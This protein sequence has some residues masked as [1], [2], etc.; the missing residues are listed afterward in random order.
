MFLG[1]RL[2]Q[3]NFVCGGTMRFPDLLEYLVG[4][5]S[6]AETRLGSPLE[7]C[8]EAPRSHYPAEPHSPYNMLATAAQDTSR[9]SE[10]KTLPMADKTLCRVSRQTGPPTAA[11][12][13]RKPL[14]GCLKTL[15]L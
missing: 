2:R 8:P 5:A 9:Q 15:A 11:R 3:L 13:C 12:D 7:K 1:D 10:V 4:F 14:V 6:A